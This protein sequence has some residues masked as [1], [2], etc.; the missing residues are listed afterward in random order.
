MSSHSS[1]EYIVC[2]IVKLFWL[3][4]Y[5]ISLLQKYYFLSAT[6]K[7]CMGQDTKI[8]EQKWYKRNHMSAWLDVLSRNEDLTEK[9][10]KV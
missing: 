8:L 9:A 2:L 7:E 5:L 10:V 1:R 6:P 3:L 4:F